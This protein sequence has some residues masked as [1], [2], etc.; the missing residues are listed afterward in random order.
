MILVTGIL[1]QGSGTKMTSI[2][3]TQKIIDTFIS[4]G[5]MDYPH[6]CCGFI[7]GGFKGLSFPLIFGCLS[8]NLGFGV[9]VVAVPLSADLGVHVAVGPCA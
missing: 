7:L 8:P 2:N 6:E 3:I 9:E 1:L 5:E 4:H